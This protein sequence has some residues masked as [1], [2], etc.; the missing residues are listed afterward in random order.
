MHHSSTRRIAVILISLVA[1][2]GLAACEPTGHP[3]CDA[4]HKQVARAESFGYHVRCDPSFPAVSGTG[5]SIVGWTDHANK[6]IWMWPDRMPDSRALRK[7]AWHEV[8]HIVWDRQNRAGTQADE[9]RWVDGYSYC[10]EPIQGVGYA[11]IPTSCT[12]YR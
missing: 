11:I 10:A 1:L 6:T 4:L 9:E 12:N 7:V 2:G 8:G 5:R 3:R